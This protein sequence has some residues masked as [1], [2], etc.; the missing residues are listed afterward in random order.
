[1]RSKLDFFVLVP[2]FISSSDGEAAAWEEDSGSGLG[3][4]DMGCS[5]SGWDW[6]E[7]CKSDIC[8]Y[9]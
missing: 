8:V 1:M 6:K 7:A 2:P 5:K 3:G 4:L 9:I